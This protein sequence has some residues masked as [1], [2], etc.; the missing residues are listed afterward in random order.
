[1]PSTPR[2]TP[3][4]ARGAPSARSGRAC[5][6]RPLPWGGAKDHT[7]LT[8]GGLERRLDGLVADASHDA[9]DEL[10]VHAADELGRVTREHMERAASEPQASVLGGVGLVP[11][12]TEDVGRCG[13]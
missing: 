8:R 6:G 13:H 3:P 2:A 9:L 5:C 1:M 10:A 4:D 12:V 7:A 11:P